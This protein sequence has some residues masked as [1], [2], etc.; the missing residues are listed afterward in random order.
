M[1]QPLIGLVMV[2]VWPGP[3]IVRQLRAPAEPEPQPHL[4]QVV[5][6]APEAGDSP[7]PRDWLATIKPSCNPDDVMLATDLHPPP[8]TGDGPALEAACFAIAGDIAKAR[9]L[10]LAMEPGKRSEA[11]GVILD[12]ALDSRDVATDASVGPVMDLVLEF[13]PNHYL[14]LYYA[15]R[16]RYLSG[17][18]GGAAPFLERFLLGYGSE[19]SLARQARRMLG[20]EGESPDR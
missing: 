17:D 9:A 15:G 8:A 19:D 2:F 3:S 4:Q 1:A 12:I 5:E 16:S 13:W 18:A 14:A 10:V 7:E 6:P 11:A 20:R